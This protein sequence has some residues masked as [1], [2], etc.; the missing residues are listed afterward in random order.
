MFQALIS[1][2]FVDMLQL[3][4][5]IFAVNLV[6]SSRHHQENIWSPWLLNPGFNWV[7]NNQSKANACLSLTKPNVI[8]YL[9]LYLYYQV[10][11][12]TS[13]CIDAGASKGK[14]WPG[15]SWQQFGLMLRMWN[16][17]LISTLCHY[18]LSMINWIMPNLHV[19]IPMESDGP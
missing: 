13:N 11:I 6:Y 17:G 2:K 19:V 8:L 16:T 1:V 14:S 7:T 10:I 15:Y 5:L 4:H 9:Y 12:L 3:I 18:Y